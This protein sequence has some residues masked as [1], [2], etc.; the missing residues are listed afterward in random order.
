MLNVTRWAWGTS[1]G[2][3]VFATVVLLL[4]ASA[5]VGETYEPGTHQ[6][7][8]TRAA[9]ADI[10][11]VD[12]VLRDELGIL[13]GILKTF[14]GVAVPDL[15]GEGAQTEDSPRNRVF[16]H[17]HNPL[18]GWNDAGFRLLG[19]QVG[20]S[21]VRWQQN[22]NQTDSVPGGGGNWA[23]QDGRRRYMQAL[24]ASAA[25]DR[26]QAFRDTFLTLGH[27]SHLV[28]DASVPAHTRNDPHPIW[29]GYETWAERTRTGA[30]TRSI[31]TGLLF[32]TPVIP[33]A[34][35]FSAG[36]LEAPIPI[37]RLID[38]DKLDPPA[39]VGALSDPTLGIGEYTNGNFLSDDTIFPDEFALPRRQ[40]L[41][42][43]SPLLEP[44]GQRF[45]R[46][47]PKISE[48]ER[49]THFVAESSLYSSV[50]QSLGQ[51]MTDALTLT[52]R[53]YQDY[54]AA[55]LPRAVGYSAALLNYFFRGQLDVRLGSTD[56]T[57]P[58]I[59]QLVGQNASPEAMANGMLQIFAEDTTGTRQQ[60][61]IM[62]PGLNASGGVDV[63]LVATGDPMPT[64]QFRP[65]F[66]DV[67]RYV[68][69]YTGD[70]GNERRDLPSGFI[71][72]VIGK[73]LGGTRAEEIIPS[74]TTPTL[75]NPDGVFP[76]PPSVAGLQTVQWGDLDN[77]FV[78]LVSQTPGSPDQA[79]AFQ[80]ARPLGS[81]VVPLAG[82]QTVDL[83]LLKSVSFPFGLSLGTTVN[84]TRSVHYRQLLVT[85]DEI[86][87]GNW[88]GEAYQFQAVDSLLP[89]ETVVDTVFPV[90]Q[91]FALVLDQA[92][93]QGGSG[94]QR[95]YAWRVAEI[96]L[97]ARGRM[98]ALVEVQL[99][100]VEVNASFS[101][102]QQVRDRNCVLQPDNTVSFFLDFPAVGK[103]YALIDVEGRAVLGTSTAP[104]FAPTERD[105]VTDTREQIRL[106]TIFNGGPAPGASGPFCFA[107]NFV[108]PDP[109]FPIEAI[110]D[111]AVPLT[112]PEAFELTGLYRSPD[113]Q[114]LVGT[115]LTLVPTFGSG[116]SV[117]RVDSQNGVNKALQY[118]RTG[119]IATG[120]LT[121]AR[122]GMRMR[123]ASGSVAEILL[124]F[125]RPVGAQIGEGEEGVLVRWAPENA[126]NSRLALT[127]ELPPATYSLAFATPRSTLV[128]QADPSGGPTSSLV[129]D[130]D[131]Q[132]AT[133]FSNQ[134]LSEQYVLLAPL[135]LYNTTD[136]HFHTIDGQLLE[137]ALP[138]ALFLAPQNPAPVATYHL[139]Q[140]K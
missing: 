59:L 126:S 43:N 87:T 6:E 98:L 20:Q 73:V 41:D 97:D 110:G 76:L 90:A 117:F 109:A 118:N 26:E 80:I 120:Y 37:A 25:A 12:R 22:Q 60:V 89:V 53:T 131:R 125:G 18:L 5:E 99:T 74:D 127:A 101:T 11:S 139:I 124:L 77:T 56:T 113:L 51:P 61:T 21:S 63:A 16:N 93:L 14:V 10:S 49:I 106:T 32:Q 1:M 129:I 100:S 115:S 31:F 75:R 114:T 107:L 79:N 40:S 81:P 88:D 121:L 105:A 2:R 116:A 133:P 122:Q 47:F 66:S 138:Q 136:T 111:V 140:L 55:L 135:F 58:D 72:A 52:R 71:G 34:E 48:G 123:P 108:N 42:L 3:L 67:A 84:F 36:R 128:R 9:R 65:P 69:V 27:L 78:G 64:I 95:P 15:I 29:E 92:H 82:D 50:T 132:S 91:S 44:V 119:A 86:A 102:R 68:V 112:G 85:V 46:Y 7:I 45:Q 54:A 23:W 96:G 57:T 19:L 70:L 62:S 8:A 28:Q 137:T 38:N 94:S 130:F 103:F 104:V 33:P 83:Q 39:N 24:T 35:I 134:D 4:S 13:E 17:F 30:A